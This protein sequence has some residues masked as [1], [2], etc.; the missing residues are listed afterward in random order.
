MLRNTPKR[1][2]ATALSALAAIAIAAA[3]FGSLVGSLAPAAAQTSAAPLRGTVYIWNDGL[4]QRAPQTAVSTGLAQ[5]RTDEHGRFEFP[6]DQRSGRIMAVKPGFDVVRREVY[7]DTVAIVL[8]QLV[9][10]G[11]FVSFNQLPQTR[12]QTWLRDLVERDLI[13]AIVMDI[14]EESG[15]VV[16]FA[17]TEMTDQIGATSPADGV[18]EFL[19]E[20]GELGVY[21]IGRIVTFLDS[22]YTA[23]HPQNALKHINGYSFIDGMGLRW[24]SP[25]SPEA[26]RYN[27]DIAVAAAEHVDEV[28]FDYVRLPYEDGLAERAIYASMGREAAINAL[29]EEAAEALHLA[30][31]AVSFDVFGVIA[32]SEDDQGIGQSIRSLSRHLD[33][34]SPMLYP[35]GWGEWSFGLRYPPS[36][37]GP[38]IR[39]SM[40]ATLARLAEGS[41]AEVRPW[42]QDFTD[43][44]EQHVYYGP[45][46]VL[47][48]V[49]E[50]AANGGYGFMLWDTRLSYQEA[51][52]EAALELTWTPR[53]SAG[54]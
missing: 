47:A 17:S 35:S 48:Q 46:Q 43:Y 49:R 44:Q 29:A 15:R 21:R 27:I 5:A 10:R 26:R 45:A 6:A 12:I 3:L 33:Y 23:W 16:Q 40:Q 42:L 11:V 4:L 1:W 41:H 19:A 20:L 28:Q 8:R 38:V 30:G 51:A 25:F 32:I 52:L 9:V 37:P 2:L 54:S 36:Q 24:S 22:R 50:T 34:I 31:A 13:N 14:K 39:Y 7:G 18:A 53:W